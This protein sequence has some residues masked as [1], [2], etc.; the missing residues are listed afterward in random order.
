MSKAYIKRWFFL[1]S[2]IL[3]AELAQKLLLIKNVLQKHFTI[4]ERLERKQVNLRSWVQIPHSAHNSEKKA[5]VREKIMEVT[6]NNILKNTTHEK[7]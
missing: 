7:I 5:E 4:N 2:S 1:E 6:I 3:Q